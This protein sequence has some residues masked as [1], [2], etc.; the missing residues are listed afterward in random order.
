MR[1]LAMYVVG[2]LV[3]S[4][5]AHADPLTYDLVAETGM[6]GGTLTGYFVWDSSIS[7]PTIGNASAFSLSYTTGGASLLSSFTNDLANSDNARILGV[8]GSILGAGGSF[9]ASLGS[10]LLEP[11]PVAEPVTWQAQ[12]WEGGVGV[13]SWEIYLGFGSSTRSPNWLAELSSTINPLDQSP[14]SST[15]GWYLTLRE[16]TSPV[17]EPASMALWGLGLAGVMVWRRRKRK[18]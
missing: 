3:C 16:E 14:L 9:S 17:P 2:L 7:A 8:G 11:V 18:A 15:L 10:A 13:A 5:T 12:R 1:T 6:N 4:A